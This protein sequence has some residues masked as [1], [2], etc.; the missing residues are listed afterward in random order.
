MINGNKDALYF[1]NQFHSFDRQFTQQS[2]FLANCGF[3]FSTNQL[4]Q[5]QAGINKYILR[6]SERTKVLKDLDKMN[7]NGHSLFP[8]LDGFSRRIK[9]KNSY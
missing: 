2:V 3:G 8:G 5:G 6:K 4:L 1:V 9:I 7:I